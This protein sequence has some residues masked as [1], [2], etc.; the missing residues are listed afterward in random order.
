MNRL[1]ARNIPVYRTDENGTIVA[2]SDG[3]NI[4]FSVGPEVI[5]L[6]LL[7]LRVQVAVIHRLIKQQH[8]KNN[9][10]AIQIHNL[11]HN[12]VLNRV[13]NQALNQKQLKLVQVEQ[14][15]LREI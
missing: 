10:L 4:T 8:Q 2:T 1:K 14:V 13:P 3:D 15:K 9:Q 6:H 7:A 12:Q 5:I 11:V